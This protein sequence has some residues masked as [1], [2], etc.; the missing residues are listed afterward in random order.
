[1][2]EEV[3]LYRLSKELEMVRNAETIKIGGETLDLIKCRA[4]LNEIYD[5][6]VS[7]IIHEYPSELH[8]KGGII[9]TFKGGYGKMDEELV[10]VI[11]KFTTANMMDT[12]FT[13]I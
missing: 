13:E 8:K 3:K 1:M 7:L 4:M 10:K 12:G 11:I 6:V 9:D 5:Y 2:E